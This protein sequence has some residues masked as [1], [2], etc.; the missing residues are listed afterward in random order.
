MKKGLTLIELLVVITMIG[1]LGVWITGEF[2]NSIKR[3][4]DAKRKSDLKAVQACMEQ[5][6]LVHNNQYQTFVVG[7]ILINSVTIQ[8]GGGNTL[9]VQ[10]PKDVAPNRYTVMASS[11]TNFTISARL[12]AP[13]GTEPDPFQ[14]SNQQ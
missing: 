13:N 6:F 9:V 2:N 7:S 1:I 12:E 14:V 4:R 8:C 11:F 3:G 5:Y 10:D